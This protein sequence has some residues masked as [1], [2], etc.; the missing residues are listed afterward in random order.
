MLARTAIRTYAS[1][2]TKPSPERIAEEI[3]RRAMDRGVG[4][5]ICPSEV[6]R[7]LADDW[8]ALMPEVRSVA[9]IYSPRVA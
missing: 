9:A 6:A 2:V 7:A 1:A 8:R 3:I 4:K 5:T